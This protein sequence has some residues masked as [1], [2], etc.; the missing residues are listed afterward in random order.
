MNGSNSYL[1]IHIQS[2]LIVA[3]AWKQKQTRQAKIK[4]WWVANL[5]ILVSYIEDV[6]IC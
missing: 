1:I 3:N 4:S 6:I 2:D 5:Y